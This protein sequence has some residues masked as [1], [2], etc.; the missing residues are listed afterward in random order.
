MHRSAKIVK[1]LATEKG[2]ELAI[3]DKAMS[4]LLEKALENLG[5]GG[6]GI[7]NIVESLLINPLA[8]YL[9]DEEIKGN[10]R[11]TL[12]DI[13]AENMPYALNCSY[14]AI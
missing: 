4:V 1:N 10:V 13:D 11:I 6:R 3:T 2:I 9:F 14:E 5:N 8:R 7:G 12:N